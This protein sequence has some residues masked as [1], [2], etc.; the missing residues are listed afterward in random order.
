MN[1]KLFLSLYGRKISFPSIVS[2]QIRPWSY[3]YARTVYIVFIFFSVHKV[4]SLI[5]KLLIYIVIRTVKCVYAVVMLIVK[6][7]FFSNGYRWPLLKSSVLRWDSG[8][9]RCGYRRSLVRFGWNFSFC[10]ATR[11]SFV[12]R[13]EVRGDETIWLVKQA[14]FLQNLKGP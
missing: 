2:T 8:V 12:I 14:I 9:Y 1:C 10:H 7:I 5:Y 3:P 4:P 11:L 6:I 13:A